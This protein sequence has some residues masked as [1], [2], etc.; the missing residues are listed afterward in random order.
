MCGKEP[1]LFKRAIM[2]SGVANNL[3]P[4]SLEE[5][6]RAYWKL[7]KLLDIPTDL[8]KEER[9][10]RL[11]SVPVHKFID[12][13]QHLD[14]VYP[15][16][17]GVQGWFWKEDV[18]GATGANVMAKCDWV[19]EIILGDCL[20]EVGFYFSPPTAGENLPDECR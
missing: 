20:V 14:N 2:Q 1:N 11:R 3:S 10:E 13:Y 9:L 12:S 4:L 15:A 5:Y 7:L 16:F 18:D 8:P 6:D 17:P 19:N